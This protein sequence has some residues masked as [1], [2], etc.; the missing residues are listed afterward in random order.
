M[1]NADRSCYESKAYTLLMQLI[2]P[3]AT[4]LPAVRFIMAS[5]SFSIE[6]G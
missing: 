4:G 3:L 2:L 1:A 5:V 6:P